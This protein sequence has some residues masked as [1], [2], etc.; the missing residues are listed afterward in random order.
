MLVSA[1]GAQKSP[2]FPTRRLQPKFAESPF[3]V[4]EV[5]RQLHISQQ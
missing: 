2:L 5:G 3:V 4:A 1:A